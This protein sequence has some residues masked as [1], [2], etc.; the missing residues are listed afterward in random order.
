[1]DIYAERAHLLALL[2]RH[3]PA[4]LVLATDPEPGFNVVLNLY[5]DGKQCGWHLSDDDLW[6]FERV[7]RYA[8]PNY[9]GHTTE[10][11]YAHIAAVAGCVLPGF[12]TGWAVI[13][14]DP[15]SLREQ[16]FLGGV[17]ATPGEAEARLEQLRDEGCAELQIVHWSG[18]DA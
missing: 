11:K 14:I 3:Y 1:V 4:E 18:A 16:G 5:I 8:F 12:M 10:E 17:F 9:D 2:S 15:M 6:L 13:G 7:T